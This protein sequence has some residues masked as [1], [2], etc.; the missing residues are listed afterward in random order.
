MVTMLLQHFK[1]VVKQRCNN[2]VTTL[3]PH[4]YGRFHNVAGNMVDQRNNNV[5]V[6]LSILK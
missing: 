4:K 3:P 6:T 1:T 5:L 2:V